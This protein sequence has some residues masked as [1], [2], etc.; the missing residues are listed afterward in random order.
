LSAGE[1]VHV[2]LNRI[3][4]D[5]RAALPVV[6]TTPEALAVR[7]LPVIRGEPF[8][9]RQLFENLI[10]N[11]AK[12]GHP[13]RPLRILIDAEAED[14]GMRVTVRD[15]GIGFRK[16]DAERV[17]VPF[18][19]LDSAA[20]RQGHGLGL[21]ICRRVVTKHGGRIEATSEPGVGSAFIVHFPADRLVH[22]A[23]DSA[24]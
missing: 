17:F 11:A 22:W 12:Y 6:S 4:D 3:V 2:D 21:A 23:A 15:N 18:A 8:Q 9:L 13:D 1:E 16:E 14:G 7:R 20:A 10:S 5:V 24:A 19:R